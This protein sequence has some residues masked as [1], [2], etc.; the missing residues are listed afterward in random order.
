[1]GPAFEAAARAVERGYGAPCTFIGCGGTIPFVTPF[2]RVLGGIPAILLGLE[3]PSCAAHS[4]NESLHLL[5]WRKGMKAAA[6][7]YAELRDVLQ[8]SS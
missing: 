6:A 4:E 1:V 2:S 7:I 8:P 5:D 3:D